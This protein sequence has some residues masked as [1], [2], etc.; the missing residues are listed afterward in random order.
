MSDTEKHVRSLEKE[1]SDLR[2]EI[3]HHEETKRSLEKRLAE[4]DVGKLPHEAERLRAQIGK[5][6]VGILI[7]KNRMEYVGRSIDG[8]LMVINKLESELEKPEIKRPKPK[9]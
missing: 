2:F 1:L 8:G 6:D 3:Y 7:A 9:M 5:L 4:I